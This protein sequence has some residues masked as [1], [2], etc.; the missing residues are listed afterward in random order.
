[1]GTYGKTKICYDIN[2]ESKSERSPTC[3]PPSS[4]SWQPKKELIDK[5]VGVVRNIGFAS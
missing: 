4:Y 3:V 5:Q 1:M 2:E